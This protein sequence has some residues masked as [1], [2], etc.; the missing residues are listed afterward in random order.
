[1]G[2]TRELICA[3]ASIGS[4]QRLRRHSKLGVCCF[5]SDF[6]RARSDG[7]VFSRGFGML[8]V[9]SGGSS[10]SHRVAANGMRP[11]V[12]R[13]GWCARAWYPRGVF[14]RGHAVSSWPLPLVRC[15][16][17]W[18]LSRRGPRGICLRAA[19]RRPTFGGD[20]EGQRNLTRRA[21]REPD[22]AERLVAA[23]AHRGCADRCHSGGGGRSEP[24][25]ARHGDRARRPDRGAA[26]PKGQNVA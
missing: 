12:R 5:R 2:P 23:A 26:A 15:A 13:D 16:R 8:R 1:M 17:R 6:V 3:Q 7:P 25:G 14:H 9:F 21:E 10:R 22:G 11:S 18:V 24:R 19:L 20:D 4:H